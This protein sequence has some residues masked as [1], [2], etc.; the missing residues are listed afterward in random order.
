MAHSHF[1]YFRLKAI[2]S[3]LT[4][5][6]LMERNQQHLVLMTCSQSCPAMGSAM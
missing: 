1:E 6:I 2:I 4:C 3:Y 5:G